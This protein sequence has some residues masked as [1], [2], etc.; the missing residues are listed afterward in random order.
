MV[1]ETGPMSR[2][3]EQGEAAV[4]PAEESPGGI[5]EG[6]LPAH[7]DTKEVPDG[8]AW[9]YCGEPFSMGAAGYSSLPLHI[10]YELRTTVRRWSWHNDKDDAYR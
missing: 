2:T 1:S 10:Y 3:G 9:P 7:R 4:V 5:G 8:G 6:L